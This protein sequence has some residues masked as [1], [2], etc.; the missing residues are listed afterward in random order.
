VAIRRH[1]LI[2]S[3]KSLDDMALAI[4]LLFLLSGHT[5]HGRTFRW[6]DPVANDP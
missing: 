2:A 4:Q 6:L 3:K 5:G 1:G